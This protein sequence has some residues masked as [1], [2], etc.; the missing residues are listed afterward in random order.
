MAA[1]DGIERPMPMNG[2]G[3]PLVVLNR[4]VSPSALLCRRWLL[5]S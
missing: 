2:R 1:P 5:R 3:D 4:V